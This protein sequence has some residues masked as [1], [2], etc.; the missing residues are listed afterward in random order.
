VTNP[1]WKREF[2]RKNGVEIELYIDG[3]GPAFVILPSYGRG[4]SA[5]FDAITARVVEAGWTVLRPQPRGIAGSKGPM[6]NLTMHDLANDVAFSIRSVSDGPAVLLGHAFGKVV[7]AWQFTIADVGPSG[8][9]QGKGGKYLFT[10]PGY[11]G[12]IPAGYLHVASPNNRIAF[13][14]RSIAAQGKTAEGLPLRADAP[15]VLPL[16]SGEPAEAEIHR[17]ERNPLPDPAVLR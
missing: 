14:F 7:D 5:D 12:E 4:I 9:D 17:S 8:L 10:P 11:S 1:R 16:G 15:H 3:E 2:L 6:T 13:A